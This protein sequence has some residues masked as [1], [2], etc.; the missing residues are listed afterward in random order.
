M[1]NTE[2]G[3]TIPSSYKVL[4]SKAKDTWEGDLMIVK[5][6]LVLFRRIYVELGRPSTLV[7]HNSITDSSTE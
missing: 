2:K 7:E 3:S 4:T 1:I 6:K 5:Q